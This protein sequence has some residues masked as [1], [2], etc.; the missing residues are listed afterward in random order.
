MDVN[1]NALRMSELRAL[2]SKHGLRGYSRLKKGE[3]IA[4]LRDSIRMETNYDAL[5]LVELRALAKELSLQ[6]YYRMK[7][8]ELIVLLRSTP[9]TVPRNDEPMLA[10]SVSVNLKF[11]SVARPPKPTRLPPSPPGHLFNPYKL[12]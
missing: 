11:R 10:L 2:A 12:E 7:K 9:N 4:F 6:G 3:L 5:R 1:Y 8:A